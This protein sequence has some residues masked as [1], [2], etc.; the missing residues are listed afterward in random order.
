MMLFR[1]A[2]IGDVEALMNLAKKSG[3]GLTSLQSDEEKITARIERSMRTIQG[4]VP[5]SEQGYL[6]VLE[7]TMA[8]KVVGVSGIEVAVGLTEP[9]YSFRTSIMSHASPQLG[10]NR[11]ERELMLCNDHTGYSELCTL[12]LDPEWRHSRNGHLLSKARLLFVA[13]FKNRFAKKIVAEMRGVQDANGKSPFWESIGRCFCEIDFAHADYLTGIGKKSFIGEL[14][15]HGPIY[16]SML[17]DEAQAAIGKVHAQTEAAKGMLEGEGFKH[18]GYVD[19]FDGGATLEAYVEDLRIVQT[20]EICK[21]APANST[22]MP[23]NFLLVSNEQANNFRAIL[24]QSS[25][26]NHSIYLTQQQIDHLE[27]DFNSTVRVASVYPEMDTP[28]SSGL[29]IPLGSNR[30]LSI[31]SMESK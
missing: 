17:S 30:E 1:P 28:N 5:L 27:I 20:S 2:R 10:I 15:P 31:S 18:E 23:D 7:D 8:H 21:V 4:L 22:V 24:A 26:D 12:F 3:S 25:R 11:F 16:T 14:M 13:G 19:I 9:W 29:A 6:F